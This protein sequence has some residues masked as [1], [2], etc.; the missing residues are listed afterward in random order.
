M[1]PKID[2][3]A[4]CFPEP[5]NVALF[6]KSVFANVIKDLEMRS[7]AIIPRGPKSSD[8]IPIETVRGESTE[9]H[10]PREDRRGY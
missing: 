7:S 5:G 2:M 9:R 6:G 10:M 1:T 3:P 8:S 4:S